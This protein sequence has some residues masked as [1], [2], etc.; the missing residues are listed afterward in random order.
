MV[1]VGTDVADE[2]EGVVILDLAHGRLGGEG[3]LDDGELIQGGVTVDGLTGVLGGTG[4]L[5]GLGQVEAGGGVD[6]AG[7]GSVGAT[8]D[9][10][11]G[12]LSLLDVYESDQHGILIDKLM[13]YRWPLD[14]IFPGTPG[15]ENCPLY[16]PSP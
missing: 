15:Q 4:E 1:L 5:Q 12:S 7:G 9:G 13:V 16:F 10:L 8:E 2:D 14:Q 11:A 3:G 6:L